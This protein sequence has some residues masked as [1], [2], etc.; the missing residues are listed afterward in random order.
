MKAT[1]IKT[2]K[3]YEVKAG[4]NTTT[5][6]VESFNPKTGSWNCA[7]KSGKNISIKDAARFVREIETKKKATTAKSK[8]NVT[9]TERI[10]GGKPKGKMSGLDAAHRVLTEAGCP[11]HIREIFE[12]AM[13]K[14]YCSLKGATPALTIS[15][16]MQR[17]I[18]GKGKNSRF[19]KTE[20]GLFAAR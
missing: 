6:K 13:Q 19:I 16:A 17:E 11:M 3:Q 20:R 5:V 1:A 7:T 15:A 18:R 4:R 12:T 2:G 8:A 14:K 10:K 9:K